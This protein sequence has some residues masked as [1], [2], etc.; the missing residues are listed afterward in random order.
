LCG[1]VKDP[2]GE[3]V[4]ATEV[5]AVVDAGFDEF[6]VIIQPGVVNPEPI[7]IDTADVFVAGVALHPDHGRVVCVSEMVPT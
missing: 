7:P 5:V 2:C 4:G 3:A 1:E 6:A